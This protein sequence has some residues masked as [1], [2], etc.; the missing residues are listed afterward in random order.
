MFDARRWNPLWSGANSWDVPPIVEQAIIDAIAA[1]ICHT[2]KK[3]AQ[4]R[5]R[6]A[7]RVGS[8]CTDLRRG[9]ADVRDLVAL[10]HGAASVVSDIVIHFT[11]PD[12]WGDIGIFSH[13]AMKA[14]ENAHYL[15]A[16]YWLQRAWEMQS[17]VDSIQARLRRLCDSVNVLNDCVH[18][19]VTA[20]ERA[21]EV[22]EDICA[23]LDGGTPSKRVSSYFVREN[24]PFQFA[25]DRAR[26]YGKSSFMH[27]NHKQ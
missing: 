19:A 2:N 16:R 8:F 24:L 7:E 20:N 13:E 1:S 26:Q 22:A 12:A 27:N 14:P 5:W 10:E 21:A 6:T 25:L 23:V 3:C 9:F 17:E 11:R 15:K 4:W 18:T